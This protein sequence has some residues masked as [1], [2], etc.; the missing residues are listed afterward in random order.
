MEPVQQGE[1]RPETGRKGSIQG[2]KAREDCTL[3]EA[4]NVC[5]EGED[6]WESKKGPLGNRRIV[7]NGKGQKDVCRLLQRMWDVRHRGDTAMNS[8]RI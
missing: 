5:L 2:Q 3:D 8:G 7:S 4:L 6:E 1:Q